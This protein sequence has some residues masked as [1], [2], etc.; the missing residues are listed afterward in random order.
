MGVSLKKGGS[1]SLTKQSQGLK[2][3][4]VGLG[5]DVNSGGAAIDLDAFAFLL[6]DLGGG[7]TQVRS[8]KDFI[9]YNNMASFDGSVRHSG[10][11]KTGEGE[12]DDEMIII[13]LSRVPQDVAVIRIDASIHDGDASG[14]NF[15][16][17][18]AAF[19]RIVNEENG[20]E[21][22]RFDLAGQVS[23]ATGIVFGVL[24]RDGGDWKF[25]AIGRPYPGGMLAAA[26]ECGVDVGGP[27][28]NAAPV[29]PVSQPAPTQDIEPASEDAELDDFDF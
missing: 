21:L 17:V 18:T 2:T 20:A 22:A 23:S 14:Q 28:P 27:P 19:I 15:G 16:M 1:V 11:N 26:H 5:W 12:G 8:D 7:Q 29:S 13:E 25:R 24:A 9:F 3:V 6:K 4:R 10:D